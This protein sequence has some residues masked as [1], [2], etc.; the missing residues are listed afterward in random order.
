MLLPAQVS[1]DAPTTITKLEIDLWPEYDRP[2]MLVIQHISLDPQLVY[3]LKLSL[4][5]PAD[6]GD[7]ENLAFVDTDGTLISISDH[8][9]NISGDWAVISFQTPKPDVQMEYYDPRLVKT[10]QERSYSY[11]WPGDYAVSALQIQL[12]EPK[13]S[14]QFTTTKDFGNGVLSTDNLVY[15]VSDVGSLAAGQTYQFDLT[16]RK[17]N[18]DLSLQS[19]KVAPSAPINGNTAGRASLNPVVLALL[20]LLALTLLGA[21]VWWY[22]SDST[23]RH[24]Q[25]NR[26]RHAH[27]TIKTAPVQNGSVFCHQCGRRAAPGDQ[28][29]RTC[30]TRLK[31]D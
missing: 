27:S 9:Q 10:S 4:R 12:Q 29:C 31:N 22:F 5:I 14:S 24:P 1:A 20:A 21:A 3:P 28:F 2:E 16:Y 30:G 7:V 8:K 25:N 19:G 17:A 18:D 26:K 23:L 6:A 13:G 11:E 15:H